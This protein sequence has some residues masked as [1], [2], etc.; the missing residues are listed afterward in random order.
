[1]IHD[2]LGFTVDD[3]CMINVSRLM[4]YGYDAPLNGL[5]INFMQMEI[6]SLLRYVRRG[7]E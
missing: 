5:F 7:N 3:V 1:M 6:N 4:V 2:N